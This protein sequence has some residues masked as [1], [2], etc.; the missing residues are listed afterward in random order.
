MYKLRTVTHMDKEETWVIRVSD[1]A[2]IPM[3]EENRDY[4]KYLAWLA[5]GNTPELWNPEA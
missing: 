3:K 2:N 5:E 4:R 1:H